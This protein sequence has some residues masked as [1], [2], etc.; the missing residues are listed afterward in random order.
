[1]TLDLCTVATCTEDVTWRIVKAAHETDRVCD[2]HRPVVGED[3]SYRVDPIC[4]SE[5]M[6]DE[7]YR[8]DHVLSLDEQAQLDARYSAMYKFEDGHDVE[9]VSL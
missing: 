2:R 8:Q 4:H 9:L 3:T 7:I 5:D 6:L 1:M